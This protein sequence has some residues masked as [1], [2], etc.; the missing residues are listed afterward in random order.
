MV[1]Y[2]WA[3]PELA[4]GCPADETVLASRQRA[5]SGELVGDDSRDVTVREADIAGVAAHV[6]D[7]TQPVGTILHLHGGGYR[8]G[9]SS[10]WCSFGSRLAAVTSATVILPDYPLAPE[11][12]FPAALHALRDLYE[13]LLDDDQPIVLSGDSAGGGLAAAFTASCRDARAPMPRGLILVS[14]WLDLTVTAAGYATRRHSDELFSAE[15]ARSAAELYLQGRHEATHPLASPL[16]ADPRGFPPVLL[17]AGGAEVLLD[18]AL[19]YTAHLTRAEV[20]VESHIV[21][22]MQHEWPVQRPDLV[23]SDHAL[24]DIARFVARVLG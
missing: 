14:P 7:P 15:S 3:L 4:A 24:A 17:F 2:E 5:R 19:A 21:A 8:S 20:S 12:P 16:F 13:R 1:R 6:V 11:A 23:E 18:D 9:S 10:G 22:G